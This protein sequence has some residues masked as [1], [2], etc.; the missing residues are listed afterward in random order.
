MRYFLLFMFSFTLMH[1]QTA[2]AG[3]GARSGAA[4]SELDAYRQQLE[5]GQDYT[6]HMDQGQLNQ[7][8]DQ[9]IESREFIAQWQRATPQQKIDFCRGADQLCQQNKDKNSCGFYKQKCQNKAFE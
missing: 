1:T 3:Q 8:M 6:G 5:P 9:K 4:M 7:Y 2:G